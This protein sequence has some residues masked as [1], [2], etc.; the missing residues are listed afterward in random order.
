MIKSEDSTIPDIRTGCTLEEAV[1]K[2]LGWMRGSQR[3]RYIQITESGIDISQLPHLYSLPSTVEEFIQEEQEI[4]KFRFVEA[5]EAYDFDSAAEWES[6]IEYWGNVC[7]RSMRYRLAL[8][9]ELD[10][11]KS[12]LKIDEALTAETGIRHITLI[13]LD[14]W[15]RLTFGI[16]I[17]DTEEDYRDGNRN[18]LPNSDRTLGECRASAILEEIRQL[19]IDP[20]QL[21]ARAKGKAGVKAA[22]WE[23]LQR[24]KDIFLDRRPFDRAWELLKSRKE[25]V[26][27]PQK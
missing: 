27:S 4:A 2:L 10:S 1:A 6:R 11:R 5:V 14:R 12:R 18:R 25:I 23:K 24:R 7:K 9:N 15:A 19:D 22:V 17:L 26:D 16:T 21:P 13:S 20:K 8:S 3:L